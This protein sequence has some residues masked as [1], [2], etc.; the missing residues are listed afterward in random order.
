LGG[1]LLLREGNTG[2]LAAFLPLYPVFLDATVTLVRRIV[3]REQI[4]SAHRTHLYQR[5]ANGGWGHAKVA[6]LYCAAAVLGL[7]VA[8]TESRPGWPII[9]L[10]Y[11]LLPLVA[12]YKLERI[13]PYQTLPHK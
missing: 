4:T 2:L 7:V 11:A 13:V 10:A 12:G 8:H 3:R 1:E 6:S 9:L 5:L